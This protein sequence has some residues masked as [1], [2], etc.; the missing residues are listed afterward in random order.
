MNIK[1]IGLTALAAS[2]VSVS[3]QAGEMSV[4]GGAS[5]AIKNNSG[6][7]AGK[8][9]TMGNQ[10]TF[11]G[12]GELDNGLN[13]SLSFVLDHA[14]NDAQG[15]DSHSITVS[16]DA[17]GSI[18]VAGDG[19]GN[20]QSALD[21]TAAGDIWDNGF[22][23]GVTDTAYI[24]MAGSDASDNSVNYT[25]PTLV[26]G[27]SISASYSS[28]GLAVDSTT[29]F[30]ATYTGVEGLSVSYGVGEAGST[31]ATA[32]GDV[33]TMKASYAIGSFTAAVSNTESDKDS[34]GIDEEMD[35]WQLSYTVSDNLSISYGEETHET[36]G[37]TVDEEFDAIS[38]SYTTGGMTLTAANYEASGIAN[39]T[40]EAGEANRWKLA[41]SFAF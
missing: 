24:A 18:T 22:A 12:G 14:D 20:A 2:L 13:V 19:A 31:T 15:F 34:T 35:S 29:A 25:L 28:G 1:K 3:A 9:I 37:Q 33:T 8:A 39:A 38:V 5:M 10:L 23:A 16:S 40:G 32:S 17:L 21:T 6:V 41:A 27:L 30:A 26:D 7:D 36:S 4:N 11:T